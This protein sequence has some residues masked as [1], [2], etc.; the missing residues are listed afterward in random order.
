MGIEHE[1]IHV[2]TSSVLH[3][4]MPLEF[5]KDVDDFKI[6]KECRDVVQNSLIS[7]PKKSIKLGKDWDDKY[8]GWDNE[9]GVCEEDL[10]K[11]SVSKY[12]VSNDEFM[13]FVKNGGY[14][15]RQYWCKEG[16]KFLDI[17]GAKHPPFWIKEKDG[18]SFRSLI[19]KIKMPLSWPVEVSNLEAMAFCRYKSQKDGIEYTLPSEAEYEAIC[20][21]VGVDDIQSELKANHNF[22]IASSVSVNINKFQTEDKSDIYDVVG[23]VWQHSRTPIYPFDGFKVHSAYDDF[24]VPT[25]DE[26]HALI[27]GSSWASSGNLIMKKSRY[28][29][30]THFYQHAGFRYVHTDSESQGIDNIYESDELVSQY[31]EFQYGDKNFDVENFAVACSKIASK[32]AIKTNKALDLGCATGRA[33]FELAKLFDEVEGIDFSVRFIGVGTRLKTKGK[34]AWISKTEGELFDKKSVSLK[35][36]GYKGLEHKVTFWQGDACNLKPNFKGYDLI[37][38]KNLIDRLYNPKLFLQSVKERTNKNGILVIA[39]PY[40]WQEESTKKEF[41]LGGYKNGDEDITTLKSLKRELQDTFELL[42]V[43]DVEFVI[44]ETNR[45]FQHSVAELS[46]WRKK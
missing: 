12:L 36:L 35:E 34:I 5:I 31:C 43:Q 46:V 3:R 8:Y 11:F 21:S 32:Y 4:Q 26:K 37:L 17:S 13:E 23:N 14:E 7:I 40:T 27:L 24:T 29:F 18:Y 42:H 19:K 30:R 33:S 22:D 45:K 6:C 20:K 10:D 28:A 15:Q 2:E 1:R 9:Y 39:S 25:F 44:K 41:W 38:A 16:R